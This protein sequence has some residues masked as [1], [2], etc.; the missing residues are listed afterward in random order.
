MVY[1]ALHDPDLVAIGGVAAAVATILLAFFARFQMAAAR[2]QVT[3]MRKSAEAQIEAL[4]ETT[5]NELELVQKQIGAVIE[6]NDRVRDAARAQ[7]QPIVFAHGFGPPTTGADIRGAPVPSGRTRVAYFL[8]NEGVGPALDVEHGISVG[9]VK[10]TVDDA[11]SRYR[12]AAAGETMP[13]GYPD[14]TKYSPL[15][16][17][18]LTAGVALVYWTRFSNVFGD[19]FE[20]LNY[21]DAGRPAVFR[22][23][24][25]DDGWQDD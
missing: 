25:S 18:V 4:K 24:P 23:L 20:V 16:I 11:G 9:G 21:P 22:M 2:D 1:A 5:A 19:R 7:L 12:T 10:H 3:T 15:A 13:P 6:G 17:D 8:K 14:D